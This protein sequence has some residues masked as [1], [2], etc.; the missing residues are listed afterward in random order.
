MSRSAITT[1][2]L[3]RITG[4]LLNCY[5]EISQADASTPRLQRS[6]SLP[7]REFIKPLRLIYYFI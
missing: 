2:S 5:L 6:F 1:A 7:V 4:S 3:Q